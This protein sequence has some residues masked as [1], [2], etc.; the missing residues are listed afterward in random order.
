MSLRVLISEAFEVYRL[1]HIVYLN[2]SK[3]TEE[4]SLGACKDLIKFTGDIPIEHLTFD[5]VRKWKEDLEKTKASGTVRGYIIKLRVVLKHLARKGKKDI[6]N[7]EMIGVP[8]AEPGVID[9]LELEEVE[10]LIDIAFRPSPGYSQLNRYRNRAII[11]FLFSSGVRVTELCNIDTGM[12]R[13]DNTFTIKGKGKKVRLCF[14]DERTREYIDEYLQLRHDDSP[15]LFLNRIGRRMNRAG[16]EAIVSNLGK[17][18][19]FTRPITPHKLRHS[20]ATDLLRNNTNLLYVSK[21][22]G[23]KSVQTTEMYTHVVDEDLRHLYTNKH[24]VLQA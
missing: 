22:L 9:F 18:A 23:H 6:L 21:F 12:L 5:V 1:E 4:M 16:V 14:I 10:R 7:F 20:Y 2:Q 8:K 11:S 24:T 13:S 15:V 19:G 3:R 17:K